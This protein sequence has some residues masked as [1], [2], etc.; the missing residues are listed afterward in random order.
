MMKEV[1]G[2]FKNEIKKGFKVAKELCFVTNDCLGFFERCQGKEVEEI[3]GDLYLD[4]QE[5]I[6]YVRVSDAEYDRIK[7]KGGRKLKKE[8][9]E[10]MKK[11]KILE[12]ILDILPE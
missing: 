6:A 11:I 7:N 4:L 12:D 3:E 5:S 1:V 9:L 8:Q 2:E 10:T